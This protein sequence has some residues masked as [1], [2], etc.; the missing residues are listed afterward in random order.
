MKLPRDLAIPLLGAHLKKSETPIQEGP[1]A[2]TFTA[3]LSAAA[4]VSVHGRERDEEDGLHV[5]AG[6]LLGPEKARTVH[7][8]Q[9]PGGT[10][11]ASG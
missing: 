10:S 9:Q 6:I 2:P 4:K 1:C 3:T 8:V 5:G 7:R 11:R